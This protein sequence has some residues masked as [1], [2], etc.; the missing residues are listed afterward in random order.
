MTSELLHPGNKGEELL[1]NQ[2]EHELSDVQE[3]RFSQQ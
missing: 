1:L 3:V 2:N